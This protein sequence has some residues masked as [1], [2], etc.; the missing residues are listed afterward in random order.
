MLLAD[1]VWPIAEWTTRDERISHNSKPDTDE[2]LRHTVAKPPQFPRPLSGSAVAFCRVRWTD[3]ND[4]R[5]PRRLAEREHVGEQPIR[6]R[7][8][9]R[10]LPMKGVREIGVA[11]LT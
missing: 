7:H 8:A 2:S 1:R 9:V 4:V 10:Q 3:A 6:A 5:S 11:A